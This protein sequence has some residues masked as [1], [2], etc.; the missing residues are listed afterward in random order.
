[1]QKEQTRFM[2]TLQIPLLQVSK[3]FHYLHMY[4]TQEDAP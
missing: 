3:H 4:T 2:V 1:M